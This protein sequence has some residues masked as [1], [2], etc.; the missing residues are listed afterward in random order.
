M[1][2]TE[3]WKSVFEP[4]TTPALVLATHVSFCLLV[5]SL[6]VFAWLSKSIHLVNLLVLAV[7]LWALVTWFIRELEALKQKEKL[8]AAGPGKQAATTTA[9][10]SHKEHSQPVKRKSRKI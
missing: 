2:V 10:G 7:V 8:E 6:V 1:F 3:L 5:V 9:T 4:G